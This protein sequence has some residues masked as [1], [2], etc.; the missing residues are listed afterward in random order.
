MILITKHLDV[1]TKQLNFF[2]CYD[3]ANGITDEEEE[4]LLQVELELFTTQTITL[5]GPK[6]LMSYIAP[7]TD[8]EELRFDFL[9]SLKKILVDEVPTHLKV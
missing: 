9:H 2:L 8:L 4:I 7:K 5:L 3:F 6:T 1:N